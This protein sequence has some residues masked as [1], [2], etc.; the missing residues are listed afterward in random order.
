M[1]QASLLL[2]CT[3]FLVSSCDNSM[4]LR[5]VQPVIDQEEQRVKSELRNRSFRLFQPSRDAPERKAVILDFFESGDQAINLW[6]Q[7]SLNGNALTEWEVSAG[8]YRSEKSGSEYRL[9]LV[10]PSS[11]RS[12]PTPCENCI[13]V[14]G[15]SISLRNL[16]DGENIQFRLNNAGNRLPSPFPVFENWTTWIEDEFV[17]E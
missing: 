17:D 12:L 10:E 5:P 14:S 4:P 16:F 15:L 1:W 9:V 2:I 13:Q 6:A 7:Y 8:D 11:I 3:A